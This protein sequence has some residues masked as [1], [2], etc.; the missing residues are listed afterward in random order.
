VTRASIS[1]L[2]SPRRNQSTSLIAAGVSDIATTFGV[3]IP[4]LGPTSRGPLRRPFAQKDP[5]PCARGA[6]TW[7][8]PSSH[9]QAMGVSQPSSVVNTIKED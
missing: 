3:S 1:G 2:F 8:G 5:G 6:H 4:L 7:E 9:G